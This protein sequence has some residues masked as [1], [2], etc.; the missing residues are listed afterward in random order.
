MRKSRRVLKRFLLYAIAFS[1]FSVCGPAGI[2]RA[3]D[4]KEYL[5]K[6]AFIYN[7][8]KFIEWPDGKAISKQSSIDICVA[9]DTPMAKTAEVFK[10]A[11]SAKL[12]LSLVQ[13]KNAKNIAS[14]C[15]IVFIGASEASR[16][17]DILGGLKGQPVLTVSDIDG[18]AARGGMIE[19]VASDNK[20]K[21]IVNTKPID[22]AKL[23]ADAG[24]LESALKVIG[25]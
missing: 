2:V 7:F 20:I 5:V 1:V 25:R 10:A 3:D 17:D 16:L 13:E 19:F 12:N 9:G 14:H 22:A 4:N 6:A 15:H 18:F 11:S 24:M 8:V 21:F 23:H